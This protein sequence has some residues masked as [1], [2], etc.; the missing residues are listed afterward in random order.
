MSEDPSRRATLDRILEHPEFRDGLALL[1]ASHR[2]D[3]PSL[4]LWALGNLAGDVQLVEAMAGALTSARIRTRVE[5]DG[6]LSPY[7]ES[8]SVEREL[9]DAQR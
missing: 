6:L 7:S 9:L 5:L 2:P 1:N 3:H 8:A 4:S